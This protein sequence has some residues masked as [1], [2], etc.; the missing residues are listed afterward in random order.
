MIYYYVFVYLYVYDSGISTI[1]MF[2]FA[3]VCVC[4]FMMDIRKCCNTRTHKALSCCVYV[5]VDMNLRY[6]AC[7][8]TVYWRYSMYIRVRVIHFQ[9][10]NDLPMV[11]LPQHCFDLRLFSHDG[12]FEHIVPT[13]DLPWNFL[14]SRCVPSSLAIEKMLGVGRGATS[15]CHGFDDLTCLP[16]FAHISPFLHEKYWSESMFTFSF[17][18]ILRINVFYESFFVQ[19]LGSP[20]L[21]MQVWLV[22]LALLPLANSILWVI[23]ANLGCSICIR[24]R[25]QRRALRHPGQPSPVICSCYMKLLL[26]MSHDKSSKSRMPV[27]S[28]QIYRI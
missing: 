16:W 18:W 1:R 12:I 24:L 7:I 8:V 22:R 11:A 13:R 21:N 3:C 19:L 9:S 4:T 23:V 10:Q 25:L 26:K 6:D 5:S 2:T 27:K 28:L 17:F 20:T 14:D 15:P